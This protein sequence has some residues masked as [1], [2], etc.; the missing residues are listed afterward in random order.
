MLFGEI[1]WI[2]TS[3]TSSIKYGKSQY[4]PHQGGMKIMKGYEKV[5]KIKLMNICKDLGVVPGA[6][7]ST[8]KVYVK[9]F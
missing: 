3:F 4:L 7:T 1:P 2:L 9:D 5:M 6:K 8:I